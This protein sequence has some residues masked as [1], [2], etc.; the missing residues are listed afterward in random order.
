VASSFCDDRR[1]PCDALL[2]A[3]GEWVFASREGY[4]IHVIAEA[5][6]NEEEGKQVAITY[7][8]FCGTHLTV[9][10]VLALEKFTRPRRRRRALPPGP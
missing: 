3:L 9:V 5:N 4:F 2:S 6:N 7:C 8:P 10:S 1:S